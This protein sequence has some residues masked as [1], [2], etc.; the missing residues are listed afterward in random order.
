MTRKRSGTS[1]AQ[2][3]EESRHALLQAGADLL[4]ETS[5]RN[6][7]AALRVRTICTEAGYTTGAFYQHW[8]DV[9]QYFDALSNFMLEDMSVFA[10]DFS[11]L[12]ELAATAPLEP[13]LDAIASLANKDFELLLGNAL[14][15]AMELFNVTWARTTYRDAAARGYREA[16]NATAAAYG[17]LL[18]R[19]GRE[20]RPPFEISTIA[21]L[22]QALIEGL[23]L[24]HRVDPTAVE[25]GSG[26]APGIYAIAAASLLAVLT[27][28]TAAS[29]DRDVWGAIND[30]LAERTASPGRG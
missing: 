15:D 1:N 9:D 8:V 4:L 12:N 7:F 25:E 6:P 2:A 29:D 26:P 30:S 18:D 20:P 11:T 17:T 24:R 23:G 19:L 10:S 13:P 3:S 27:R 14:W 16:D 22:L 28:P 5:Q 21:I